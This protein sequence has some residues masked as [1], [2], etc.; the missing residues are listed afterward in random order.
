MIKVYYTIFLIFSLNISF[1]QVNPNIQNWQT[2]DC[3]LT[4]FSNGEVIPYAQTPREWKD[5]CT[6]KR[7]CYMKT[8]QGSFLYNYYSIVDKRG[9][10][11]KGYKVASINDFEDLLISL[12]HS[13]GSTSAQ[14][15]LNYNFYI[16][17]WDEKAG[18]LSSKE[19]KGFNTIG[20]NT[21]KT[22]YIDF[23]GM[24]GGIGGDSEIDNKYVDILDINSDLPCSFWWT[25][26]TDGL[27]G[28][29][30]LGYCSEDWIGYQNEELGFTYVGPGS[31]YQL[32]M[33]GFSVRFVKSIESGEE[34]L[35]ASF[36]PIEEDFEKLFFGDTW[37][38]TNLYPVPNY[39]PDG[40]WL[41]IEK[42][43]DNKTYIVQGEDQNIESVQLVDIVYSENKIRLNITAKFS[44]DVIYPQGIITNEYGDKEWEMAGIIIVE[45]GIE[46]Y[47]GIIQKGPNGRIPLK[48][49]WP[50]NIK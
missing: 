44:I 5:Y 8:K 38:I 24:W 17:G 4:S 22:G 49:N 39:K 32:D 20:F 46:K 2:N 31:E 36:Q 41:H 23:Y 48:E 9:I 26:S 42:E 43:D 40:K 30:S 29:F 10:A 3:K 37:V 50:G 25:T 12:D 7:P 47:S 13:S 33:M 11:P 15:L 1:G 6:N 18:E 21:E 14:Q 34:K 16:E 35:D 45:D 28:V 19:Y 27:L